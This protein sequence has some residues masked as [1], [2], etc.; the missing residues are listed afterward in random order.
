MAMP[1]PEIMMP[2]WPV[3]RNVAAIPR[4][5]KFLASASAVYFLPRA[6]SVPTVRTR[7]P[8]RLRPV[9]AP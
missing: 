5:C 2:V 8:L 3:A 1:D 9:A 7:L 4:D 6:Q